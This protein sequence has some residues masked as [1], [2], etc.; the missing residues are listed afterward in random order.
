MVVSQAEVTPIDD[1]PRPTPM[2]STTVLNTNSPSTVSARCDQVAP[3]SPAST[4]ENTDSTGAA[5]S[6]ATT[7]A[8]TDSEENRLRI[9]PCPAFEPMPFP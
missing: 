2:Q 3:V 5:I 6:A 8:A 7:T 1:T 4:L 9:A